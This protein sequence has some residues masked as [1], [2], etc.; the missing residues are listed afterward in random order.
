MKVRSR[1]L[2]LD[3][4]VGDAE[5][6]QWDL[7]Q[8]SPITAIELRFEGTTG[9]GVPVGPPLLNEI[10]NLRV[11]DGSKQFQSAGRAKYLDGMGYGNGHKMSVPVIE[12]TASEVAQQTMMLYFG[13]YFGDREYYLDPRMMNNPQLQFTSAL[14]IAANNYAT[15]TLTV[16][17]IVHT[18][19]GADLNHRG[20]MVVK[21]VIAQTVAAAAVIRTDMPVDLPWWNLGIFNENAA[22]LPLQ[23]IPTIVNYELDINNGEQSPF[24]YRA[25]DLMQD[26]ARDLGVI[27]VIEA[28]LTDWAV[29]LGMGI[30]LP[31][32]TLESNMICPYGG[33]FVPF[34]HIYRQQALELSPNDQARLI[35]T[36]GATGGVARI[37]LAQLA[38]TSYFG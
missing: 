5:T 18:L 12:V 38:D 27:N 25:Q 20:V 36:G 13:R 11:I 30:Q 9:A 4:A 33:L 16:T 7:R 22:G 35:T 14:T 8:N 32:V 23:P 24:E 28:Q 15:G 31:N 34:W 37:V 6:L 10:D 17:I 29:N 2:E 21:E 19:E 3:R 26:N 1:Y